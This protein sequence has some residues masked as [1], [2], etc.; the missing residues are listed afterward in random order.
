MCRM[1]WGRSEARTRRSTT[2]TRAGTFTLQKPGGDTSTGRHNVVQKKS[3]KFILQY[4]K[5]VKYHLCCTHIVKKVGSRLHE[6]ALPRPKSAI[7][8]P[9]VCIVKNSLEGLIIR[10]QISPHSGIPT[11]HPASWSTLRTNWG[12]APT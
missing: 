6:S 9:R 2:S 3:G 5:L 8:Q 10:L 12:A 11:P 4:S 7:T 1:E